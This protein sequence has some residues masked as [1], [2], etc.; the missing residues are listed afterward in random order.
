M[1]SES[2]A[3]LGER[4]LSTLDAVA[5]SLAIGP[6]FSGVFLTFLIVIQAGWNTLL[7]V[8]LGSIGVLCL[9]WVVSVYARRY[10]GAG[11]IYELSLIHI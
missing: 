5:Q 4:R 6:I 10:S 3:H 1:S 11:A 9:G 7:S 8:V 2:R